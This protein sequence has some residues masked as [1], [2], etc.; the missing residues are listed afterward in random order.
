MDQGPA[1]IRV[2]LQLLEIRFRDFQEIL[3]VLE[4]KRQ[5]EHE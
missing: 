1:L 3:T 5:V 4:L 2:G